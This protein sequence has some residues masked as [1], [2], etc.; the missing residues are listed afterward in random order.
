VT[1]IVKLAGTEIFFYEHP[2]S[3]RSKNIELQE[4]TDKLL[5]T[6]FARAARV[7]IRPTYLKLKGGGVGINHCGDRQI[8]FDLS[9]YLLC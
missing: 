7:L 9:Q 3:S 4:C 1:K 6:L 5:F 2:E 8:F